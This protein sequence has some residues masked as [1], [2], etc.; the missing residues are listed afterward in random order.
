MSDAA[1]TSR[2]MAGLVA[3][4]VLAAA[5]F[6]L[7]G[8]RGDWSF[9]L[10]FR[11]TRLAQLCLVA[12]AV[13]MATLMFQTVTGNRI[14]TPAVMGLD[15]LFVLLQT[16]L[17]HAVGALAATALPTLPMFLLQAVAMVLFASV[18]YRKLFS[19]DARSLHLMVMTGIV[20]GT[21][22][23]SLATFVQGLIDPNE[24]VVLQNRLFADFSTAN[25]AL[26]PGA[27][28]VVTVATVLGWRGLR[29]LDVLALGRER[30]IGLGVP[31]A[32]AVRNVLALVALLVAVS[33]ALVGPLSFLG[34]LVVHLAYRLVPSQ[35][36][37][38]L[39]PAASL[40]GITVLVGGQWALERLLGFG[41][42]L[43][44]VIEFAGGLLF[45]LLLLKGR[46]SP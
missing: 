42:A 21:A 16:V 26:L 25:T 18:L 46:T 31:H 39:L 8:A 30:A 3:L 15:S 5:V 33:T 13:A 24:F 20:L 9:V 37:A 6:L 44:I 23:R 19:G 40:L 22:F 14:L 2:R 43:S 11:G 34:L 32:R 36:H 35:R 41:T 27:A 10:P 12:H 7:Q 38:V 29:E 45:L 17:F 28:A 4:A 1:V